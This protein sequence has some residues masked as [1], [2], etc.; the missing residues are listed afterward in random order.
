MQRAGFHAAILLAVLLASAAQDRDVYAEPSRP[1]QL[2][3][4]FERHYGADLAAVEKRVAW[5]SEYDL[6]VAL[7]LERASARKLDEIVTWRREGGSWDAITRRVGLRCG[8]Y[9]VE[10]PAEEQLPAPY[11]RPYLAWREH[12]GADQRLTD[13]EVREFVLLRALRDTC[14]LSAAEIAHLRAAGK[15]P[16]AIGTMPP[17]QP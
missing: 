17:S 4:L 1:L 11:S 10:L 3:F 7:H 6:L 16:R 5:I 14:R 15:S 2:G 8:I 13:E 9:Y 12:P